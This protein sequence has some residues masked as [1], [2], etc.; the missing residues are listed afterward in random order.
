VPSVV[1]SDRL[2]LCCVGMVEVSIIIPFRGDAATLLWTLE[3][4]SRQRLPADVSLIV[5][6]GGDGC[7]PPEFVSSNPRIRFDL[8]TLPRSGA[9]R[10]RNLLL[11]DARSEVIIFVNADTRPAEDFVS[12]HVR[13]I[14]SLPSG[15]MVLGRS[16]YEPAAQKTVFDVLKEDSPMVFFYDRL[17]PNRFYDYRHAW[18]LNL[19]VRLS[20]FRRGGGFSETLRPYY[21]EDLD[22]AFKIMGDKAAVYYDPQ[23][24]VTHRHPMSL[25]QYLDREEVLG[26][27][28]PVLS[29]VNPPVFRGLLGTSDLDI[30]AR[31][32]R[33][34]VAMDRAAHRWTYER[35]GQ[36]V[37]EPD[38]VLGAEG[39]PERKRLLLTLYQLHI[40]LKR[41][42]FR[43]GFLRGLELMDDSHWLERGSVGLWKQALQ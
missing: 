39:S 43:L 37:N 8:R 12:M 30:L 3:G 18:T 10:V 4:F 32:Y 1:H 42:A 7:A 40:P 28:A 17:E 29:R 24:Q 25:D 31:D 26:T 11:E 27:V 19:S 41:L 13:R 2:G 16:P 36:W 20:D 35:L 15:S 38:T 5:R 21:Y 9:A 14:L 34:W 22:V 23:A 6:V 33:T